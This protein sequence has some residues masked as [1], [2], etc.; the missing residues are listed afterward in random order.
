MRIAIFANQEQKKELLE[1]RVNDDIEVIWLNEQKNV[2]TADA[3]IDLLFNDESTARNIFIENIPVFANAVI[4]TA[5][6]LPSNYVRIN[7]WNGFV[8]R[9]I[10]EVAAANETGK[11]N[12][13]AILH[14][15]GWKFVWSP[16]EPGMITARIIA[17]IINEAYFAL[18]EKVSTKEGIDIAMKLGT[19]YPYGPF[20]WSKKIGLAKILALLKRLSE[21]ENRYEIAPMLIEEAKADENASTISIKT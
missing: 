18:G 21:K 15:L 9:D 13:Q 3:C 5:S 17:M 2:A 14:E 8:K 11:E 10:I 4:T 6:E 7:G 1:K 12:W 20:E 16:D 19:N